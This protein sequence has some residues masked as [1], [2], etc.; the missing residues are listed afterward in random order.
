MKTKLYWGKLLRAQYTQSYFLVGEGRC[1]DPVSANY[2]LEE[3]HVFEVKQ[4]HSSI[5]SYFTLSVQ[6]LYVHL[7]EES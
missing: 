5:Q 3:R 1:E 7:Y 2:I 4:L 6:L